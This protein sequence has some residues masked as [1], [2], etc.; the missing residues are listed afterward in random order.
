MLFVVSAL[1]NSGCVAAAVLTVRLGRDARTDAAARG[2][3][4]MAVVVALAGGMTAAVFF[5]VAAIATVSSAIWLPRQVPVRRRILLIVASS[6]TC[7]SGPALR[8]ISASRGADILDVP[9]A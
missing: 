3:L 1:R 8:S 9:V 4:K 6:P 5:V 7:S 2:G